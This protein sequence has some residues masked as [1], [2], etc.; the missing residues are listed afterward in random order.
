MWQKSVVARA[1][2]WLTGE[3]R[4]P[5]AAR[6]SRRSTDAGPQH[7]GVGCRGVGRTSV[8]QDGLWVFLAR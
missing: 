3:S 5:T 1:V 6:L 8:L 4:Q 7:E 2:L